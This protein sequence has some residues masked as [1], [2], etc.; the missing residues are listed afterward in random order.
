MRRLCVR[1]DCDPLSSPGSECIERDGA[2]SAPN[3][4]LL[5][6]LRGAESTLCV[7]NAVA[8]YASLVGCR[9]TAKLIESARFRRVDAVL[10]EPWDECGTPATDAVRV[11][12]GEFRWLPIAI[13]CRLEPLEAREIIALG[14]AGA[15]LVVLRGYDVL[16]RTLRE[17]LARTRAR[18]IA[19]AVLPA[20]EDTLPRSVVPVL[21]YC[22]DHADAALT[23]VTVAR[24]LSLSRKTLANRLAAAG[25][26]APSAI[27]SWCRVLLAARLLEDR[28]RSVEGIALALHFGSSAA[29]R[30][31]LRRYT[32]LRTSQIRAGGLDCVLTMFRNR[33]VRRDVGALV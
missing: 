27:I 23:V 31:M 14:K 8:G 30:N 21:A 33:L 29:L 26:P 7:R 1:P 20:V 25:L 18:R 6:L 24:A 28:A 9:T 15:D 32:G 3:A 19:H 16:H 22:L 11:L 13:Y 10:V 12:R 5:A 4:T 17:L 2:S